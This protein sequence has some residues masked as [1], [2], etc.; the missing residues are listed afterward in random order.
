LESHPLGLA[1]AGFAR[2]SR[3]E[4]LAVPNGGLM[5][6]ADNELDFCLTEKLA[7]LPRPVSL[8]L[9]V[10]ASATRPL[11]PSPTCA[12]SPLVGVGPAFPYDSDFI[13]APH[14]FFG[15]NMA[16]DAGQSDVGILNAFAGLFGQ[17]G[18]VKTHHHT[19]PERDNRAGHKLTTRS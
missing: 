13:L 19:N 8:R 4:T 18:L 9:R 7:R 6:R 11:P 14:P 15:E 5:N 3:L 16:A 10:S 17:P 2:D 1:V 12:R